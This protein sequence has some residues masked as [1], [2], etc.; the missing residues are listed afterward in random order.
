MPPPQPV[1]TAS[2]PCALSAETGA[3]GRVT[4]AQF[5]RRLYASAAALALNRM[6]TGPRR[7]AFVAHL[8]EL[9]IGIPLRPFA[10]VRESRADRIEQ[11]GLLR[12]AREV[13]ARG[14]GVARLMVAIAGEGVE[15]AIARLSPTVGH[16][17]G[18]GQRHIEQHGH[19]PLGE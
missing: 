4:S 14:P 15:P 16:V 5:T 13:P 17:V 2:P 10:V 11:L 7:R 19:A 1:R 8:P 9:G 3:P 18:A 6:R 12:C